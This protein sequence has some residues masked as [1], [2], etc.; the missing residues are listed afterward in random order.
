MRRD[1]VRAIDSLVGRSDDRMTP[2]QQQKH[3]DPT[4]TKSTAN[5][6]ETLLLCAIKRIPHR[7]TFITQ[8]ATK[9]SRI[10]I[11]TPSSIAS[12]RQVQGHLLRALIR[13]DFSLASNASFSSQRSGTTPVVLSYRSVV[14]ASLCPPISNSRITRTVRTMATS[15]P[16]EPAS[17]N[18]APEVT[19]PALSG[20]EASKRLAAYKAVEDHFDV[21]YRYIGIG[22]GSTVVYVVEAI[23]AKGRDVTSRMI[24][25]PTYGIPS[26]ILLI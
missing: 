23:A 15:Q 18:A 3:L 16:S 20:V 8:S 2:L 26:S 24:F 17:V 7:A 13:R 5:F 14:P 25:V 22:S 11:Q 6:M 1:L 12:T 21:N 9:S 4:K 19:P 10:R